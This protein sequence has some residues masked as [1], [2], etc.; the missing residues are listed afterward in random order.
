MFRFSPTLASVASLC[1]LS[2]CKSVV[3]FPAGDVAQQQSHILM[4]SVYLMLFIVV[5]VMGLTVW[6]AWH[7][8]ESNQKARYTPDWDHSTALELVIWSGPLFI[9]I[10]LGA[11]TWL[12]THML[13]PYRP[14]HRLSATQPVTKGTVPLEV[15][16]VALDWK[17]L[18]FYPKYGI[19][20]VNELAAPVNQP[21]KFYLTASTVMNAFYIP[22]LAGQIYTMP[23]MQTQLSAVMNKTGEYV[24]FSSNYSGAGFSHMRF[25]F[26]A[27]EEREFSAWVEGVKSKGGELNGKNYLDLERPSEKEP[28]RYYAKVQSGLYQSI[29]NMCVRPGS[30]CMNEMAAIDT[31]GGLDAS[32][33]YN[34]LARATTPYPPRQTVL[35]PDKTY[36]GTL[37]ATNGLESA[38]NPLLPLYPASPLPLTGANI[39]APLFNS[40]NNL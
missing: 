33:S 14:L 17:W 7:Y 23:G 29:L 24:G 19:A 8:R 34:M 2:A 30:M 16:V 31:R 22:D 15:E 3:L 27:M 13:D 38:R 32:S 40:A 6:F 37:C 5:P 10:L 12:G 36:V 26:K 9:V 35:G 11:V 4:T 39:P 25:A 20:T 1:A 18:F 28:V 21:I